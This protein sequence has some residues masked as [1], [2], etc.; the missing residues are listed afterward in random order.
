MAPAHDRPKR[1]KSHEQFGSP[2]QSRARTQREV[3]EHL[4]V[5]VD[6]VRHVRDRERLRGRL[7]LVRLTNSGGNLL[8]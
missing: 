5:E 6:E 2:Q 1:Q 7:E 4:G 8:K 3:A